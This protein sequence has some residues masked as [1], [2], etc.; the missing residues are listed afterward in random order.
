MIPPPIHTTFLGIVFDARAP[1]LETITS[2]SN[3]TPGKE[4]GLLPVAIIIFF[5][6]RTYFLPVSKST[7]T[8]FLFF[9]VPQPLI[10]STL[11][12]INNPAIPPVNPV[13]IEALLA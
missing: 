4:F 9:N 13:T 7:D 11:F 10:H 5:A 6:E 12:F 1:V 3:S 2:S 8:S